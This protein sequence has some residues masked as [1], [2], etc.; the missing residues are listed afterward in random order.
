[1]KKYLISI[2]IIITAA[3]VFALNN[4]YLD[5]Y[6][7]SAMADKFANGGGKKLYY[8]GWG[9]RAGY[10]ILGNFNILAAFELASKDGDFGSS[11]GMQGDYDSMSCIGGLEYIHPFPFLE[12]LKLQ[13]ALMGGWASHD[14]GSQDTNAIVLYA[15]AGVQYDLTQNIT[16]FVTGSFRYD[17]TD[18][19]DFDDS[20]GFGFRFGV[21]FV[22]GSNKPIFE[23]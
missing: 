21:R 10:H 2:I 7:V 22:F 4:I 3:P 13:A 14:I 12:Q 6:R 16:P 18:S 9:A 5:G 17:M 1:M 8:Y 20:K 15:E 19:S 23:D 11:P